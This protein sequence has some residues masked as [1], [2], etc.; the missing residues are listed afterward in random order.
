MNTILKVILGMVLFASVG[1]AMGQEKVGIRFDKSMSW[2]EVVRKAT[3]E[4]KYIFMDVMATW[5]GPC[6]SMAQ[7]VFPNEE[8]GAFFNAN[9]ICIKLQLDKTAKDD[10]YVQAWYAFAQETPKR[11]NIQTVPTLLFFSPKGEIVHSMPGATTNTKAFIDLG[12]MALDE[13]QQ[14][15]TRLRK[16]E[17]GERDVEF[18]YDLSVDLAMQRDGRNAIKVANTFWRTLSPEERLLDKGTAKRKL[19]GVIERE[20]VVPH[21]KDSAKMPEWEAIYRAL[22]AKY[23]VLDVELREMVAN[24]KMIYGQRF[25]YDDLYLEALQELIPI[26]GNTG[27]RTIARSLAHS[28]GIKGKTVEQ[29]RFALDWSRKMLDENDPVGI[30]YY[31][32]LLF[33][34]GQK[35]EGKKYINL[36]MKVMGKGT[37]VYTE[38]KRINKQYVE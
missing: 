20:M 7:Q 17:N 31:A 12:K 3:R 1:S 35:K 4:N 11:F 5:C 23:P 10:E 14:L 15:Y 18:L 22:S 24:R 28:L 26:S 2:D 21:V 34:S 29:K 8:V 13:N 25:H 27:N 38:V 36:A 37:L 33:M 32:E 16:Y 9:F 30:A 6:R 19:I